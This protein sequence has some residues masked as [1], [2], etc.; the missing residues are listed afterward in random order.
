M[1]H[2]LFF[3]I[4][5]FAGLYAQAQSDMS[6]YN[7]F[8]AEGDRFYNAQNYTEALNS[9]NAAMVACKDKMLEVQK[10]TQTVF[11]KINHL[12]A[13]AEIARK[14]AIEQSRIAELEKLNAY[15]EKNRSDSLLQVTQAAITR[16]DTMQRKVETAMF[17]KAVKEKNKEW[18]GHDKY[19][20]SKGYEYETKKGIEI[21]QK[22]DSLNL[23]ELALMRI[24]IEVLKCPNLKHINLLG[25]NSINWTQ[26]AE[27]LSK[28]NA[29]TGIYV[30]ISD[31]SVIDSSYWDLITGIEILKNRLTEIPPTILQQKQLIYL[32]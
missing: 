18:K 14:N 11:N 6:K 8:I 9:Y 1:K 12:K 21:L 32:D 5:L 30:S 13:E 25:N 24:P 19:D 2:I 31:L 10:K 20:W 15:R 28:L 26:S 7:R 17:D 27:T 22:V 4:L 16:A 3:I 23:S 29:N